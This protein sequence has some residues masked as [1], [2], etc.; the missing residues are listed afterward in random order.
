MA[1]LDQIANYVADELPYKFNGDYVALG[2]VV[3][4]GTDK[5]LSDNISNYKLLIITVFNDTTK[6]A[7]ATGIV[8]VEIFKLYTTVSHSFG[9]NTYNN[10][11]VYGYLNY[12]NDTTVHTQISQGRGIAI[13]GLK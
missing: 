12:V 6:A 7:E 5:V 13:Y 4:D 11:R 9:V 3:T 8:P 1:N 2:S 10:G